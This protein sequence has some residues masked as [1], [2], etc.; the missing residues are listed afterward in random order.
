MCYL[1]LAPGSF[2]QLV[3]SGPSLEE[4]AVYFRSTSYFE[5]NT[6]IQ[7]TYWYDVNLGR[8]CEFLISCY[9]VDTT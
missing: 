1:S 4:T 8:K 7:I 6:T 2:L 3:Q 5:P 9:I